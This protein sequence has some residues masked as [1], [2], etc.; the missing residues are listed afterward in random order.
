MNNP[1]NFGF[2]RVEV[3]KT[4]K[5]GKFFDYNLDHVINC[6]KNIV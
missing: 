4:F 2:V 5:Y 1:E 6:G 3:N